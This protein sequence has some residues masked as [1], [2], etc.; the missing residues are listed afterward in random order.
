MTQPPLIGITVQQDT[1]YTGIRCREAYYLRI[2]AAGGLPFLLPPLPTQAPNYLPHLDGLLLT[3]GGD[4][5]ASL[6]GQTPIPG[7]LDP[8]E[9]RDRFELSLTRQAWAIRLPILGICRGMQVLNV[10]LGGDIWQD[11]SLRGQP[12]LNHDQQQPRHHTSHPVHITQETIAAQ[13]GGCCLQVN[14]HHHQAVKTVAPELLATGL[15]PDGIV[16]IIQSPNPHRFALG[17]Q[18]H[19]ECLPEQS[20]PFRMLVMAAAAYQNQAANRP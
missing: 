18:W 6:F 8:D 16:E 15:A 14:S 3:G 11:I 7:A 20:A 13:L 17:L 19:P 5:A 12:A 4:I 1:A 9:A 10:A 2:L